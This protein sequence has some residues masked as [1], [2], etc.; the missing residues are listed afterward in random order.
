MSL[1]NI[2]VNIPNTRVTPSS[3]EELK[4]IINDVMKVDGPL[5]DLNFIDT[6]H[7]TD[8]STLFTLSD[9]A[10]DISRWDTSNVRNMSNMFMSSPFNGDISSWDVSNVINMSYM[11]SGSKFDGDISQWDTSR[12]Y[13]M[14]YM[15][16][17]SQFKGDISSWNISNVCE[18][19]GMFYYSYNFDHKPYDWSKWKS[20]PTFSTKV[21]DV[22]YIGNV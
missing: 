15:F 22:E 18:M 11:F 3:I 2:F 12:V 8:M 16:S 9:F 19:E 17:F 13:S 10:G 21:F 20:N 7:I 5:C 6:S 1:S 4:G 14:S